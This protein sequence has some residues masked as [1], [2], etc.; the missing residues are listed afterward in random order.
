MITTDKTLFDF[1]LIYG[2]LSQSYWAK[3]MPRK[4]MQTAIKNSLCFGV[5]EDNQQIGFARV[6]TDRAIFAYLA[7]VFILPN[8]QGRGF[9]KELIKEIVNHS[10]LQG[11]R[12][13]M[14]ATA[15]AHG[16]YTKFGFTSVT[17]PEMLMENWQPDVYQKFM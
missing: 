2:Y 5:F 16:L 6:I 8:Y 4:V 9:S 13:M 11:L 1:E 10:D 3:G 15:D 14:L 12:R 17:N 7:D